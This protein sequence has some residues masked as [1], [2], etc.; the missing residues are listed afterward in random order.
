MKVLGAASPFHVAL[1]L[2]HL[3]T[4]RKTAS[5]LESAAHSIAWMHQLGGEPSSTDHPLVK[6]IRSDAQRL[7][8]HHTVAKKEPI[9][10]PARTI[11]CL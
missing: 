5:P 9:S 3:M 6:S 11:S 2:C 1:Y 4:D 8:A 7:L 10:L